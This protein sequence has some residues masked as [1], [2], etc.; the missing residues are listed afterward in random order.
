MNL[1]HLFSKLL[2]LLAI[3]I[4]KIS[5]DFGGEAIIIKLQKLVITEITPLASI[6]LDLFK[7]VEFM[8]VNTFLIWDKVSKNLRN[9][10]CL[11][12]IYCSLNSLIIK[13]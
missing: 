5:I 12:K 11:T 2:L 8:L 10:V 3:I 7:R 6:L 9:S 1:T 4:S 13:T